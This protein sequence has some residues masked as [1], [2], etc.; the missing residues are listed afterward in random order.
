MDLGPG[1]ANCGSCRKNPEVSKSQTD[2][3]PLKGLVQIDRAKLLRH[4]CGA[5][6]ERDWTTESRKRQAA[7]MRQSQEALF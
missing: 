3:C 7:E 4:D 2:R 6:V 5:F 1:N